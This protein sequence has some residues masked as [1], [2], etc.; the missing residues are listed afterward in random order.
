[1]VILADDLAKNLKAF[2]RVPKPFVVKAC[3][4]GYEKERRVVKHSLLTV[5]YGKRTVTIAH[6]ILRKCLESLLAQSI[7]IDVNTEG[8][9]VHYE[10][11]Y[12]FLKNLGEHADAVRLHLD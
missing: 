6:D 8:L 11:G 9:C 1:M 5:S 3:D 10:C 7:R 12:L 4:Y 2:G